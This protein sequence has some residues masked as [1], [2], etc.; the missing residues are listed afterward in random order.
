MISACKPGVHR[1]DHD[2]CEEGNSWDFN[3]PSQRAKAVKLLDAE[4]PLMLITCPM[5]GPFLQP[6]LLEIKEV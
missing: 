3:L 2:R 1:P 5:V 6:Q 4:K